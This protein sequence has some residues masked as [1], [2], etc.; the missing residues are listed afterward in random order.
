VVY[1]RLKQSVNLI[2]NGVPHPESDN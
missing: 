1:M 2:T